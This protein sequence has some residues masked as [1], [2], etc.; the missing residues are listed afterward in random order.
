MDPTSV[1][2][3]CNV[4]DE[5]FGSDDAKLGKVT[6][7]DASVV[8]VEHGLLHKSQLYVPMSAVNSCDAG[9]VYLNVTKDEAEHQGWDVP[10]PVDTEASG[11][12]LG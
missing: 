7:A 12:P 9:K 1:Q 6:A 4:G 3:P 8:T 10:P 2:R 11:R 5:V